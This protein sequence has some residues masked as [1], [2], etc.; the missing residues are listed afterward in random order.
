MG[1]DEDLD[2]DMDESDDEIEIDGFEL[3]K[4]LKESGQFDDVYFE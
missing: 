2:D 4:L 1:I 3:D